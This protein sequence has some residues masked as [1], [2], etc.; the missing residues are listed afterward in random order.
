MRP[1]RKHEKFV[2]D[3]PAVFAVNENDEYVVKSLFFS[4]DF[5]LL[6]LIIIQQGLN[7]MGCTN[8]QNPTK[9]RLRKT[10]KAINM[11]FSKKRCKEKT[12]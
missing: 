4:I 8:D 5:S 2:S 1:N 3:T 9:I 12:T 6:C 11:R 10:K 7:A